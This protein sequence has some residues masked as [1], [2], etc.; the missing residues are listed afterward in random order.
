[1]QEPDETRTTSSTGVP[2]A[3]ERRASDPEDAEVFRSAAKGAVLGFTAIAGLVALGFV[4]VGV[5]VGGAIGVGAFIGFW[6]GT[7]FGFMIGGSSAMG[8]LEGSAALA[9]PSREPA[10]ADLPAAEA[11]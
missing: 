5:P 9:E 4:L 6:G 3:G 1:M 7:G 11:A 8:R 10:P 2:Y